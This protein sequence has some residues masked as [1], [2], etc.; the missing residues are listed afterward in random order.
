[1][2]FSVSSSSEVQPENIFVGML[3]ISEFILTVFREVQP[4]NTLSP[5]V[6]TF[7]GIVTDSREVQF[8]NAYSST[9]VFV[10]EN[11]SSVTEVFPE[12][13]FLSITVTG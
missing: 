13:A 6:T 1:M 10:L 3:T 2:S 12:K 5:K 9:V 7:S 8:M 4:E 11:T